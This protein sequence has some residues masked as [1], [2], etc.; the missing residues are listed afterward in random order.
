MN[1]IETRDLTKRFGDHAAVDH[2]NLSVPAGSVFG[3]LGPNGAGKTT[4]LRILVGLARPTSGDAVILGESIL[5]PGRNYLR[6]VGFLPDVPGFYDWMRAPEFLALTGN[7]FGMGGRDLKTRIDEVLELTGLAGVK[8]R[9]GGFSRG[10]KQR[11]GMAQALVNRPELIFLDEPTSALD[12]LGRKEVLE[13][14]ERLAGQ[15]TVFFSTHILN[16]VERVCDNVAIL[17]QGCLVT[18]RGIQ[19]LRETFAQHFIDVEFDGDADLLELARNEPWAGTITR[20]H[21]G[22]RV[23]PADL[24]AAQ[25]HLPELIVA[26]HLT[27]RCFELVEPS[28]EDIFMR[29]VNGQ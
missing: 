8:T 18:Q 10:M 4:T 2:L 27:L 12:P 1:A 16:D 3:F 28:L 14:I 5:N 26:N 22:W 15:T 24:R 17:N 19:E 23:N 25:Q 21:E 9:I 11:L 7:I 6:R 13:T 20:R 29:L